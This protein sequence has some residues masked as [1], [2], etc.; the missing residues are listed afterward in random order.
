MMDIALGIGVILGAVALSVFIVSRGSTAGSEY[1]LARIGADVLAILDEQ[2]AFDD[3]SH[4]VIEQKMQDVLPA[5]LDMLLRIEGDFDEGD[6]LIEVGGNLPTTK[7]LLPVR[8]VVLTS[9]DT[10]LKITGDVWLR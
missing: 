4:T 3:L 1:Q 5:H 6:G 10:Y 7:S 9:D 8:R 2:H